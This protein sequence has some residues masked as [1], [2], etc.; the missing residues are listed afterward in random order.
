M[1][2]ASR[3]LLAEID[4]LRDDNKDPDQLSKVLLENKQLR[5]KLAVAEEQIN[6][7]YE[8]VNNKLRSIMVGNYSYLVDS[9]RSQIAS[10]FEEALSKIRGE[11]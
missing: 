9:Y 7:L 5:E 4:R 11:K 3:E 8:K 6:T 1:W 10:V 2:E